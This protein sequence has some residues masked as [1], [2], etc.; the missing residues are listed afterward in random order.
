M[1]IKKNFRG[2]D[3]LFGIKIEEKLW[4]KESTNEEQTIKN[5]KCYKLVYNIQGKFFFTWI[6]FVV[7][8]Y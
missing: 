5:N 6:F 1:N 3:I 4:Y 8:L 7:V 2:S